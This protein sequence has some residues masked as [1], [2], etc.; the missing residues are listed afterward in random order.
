MV[1]V[2]KR[3]GSTAAPKPIEG[4]TPARLMRNTLDMSKGGV[5]APNPGRLRHGKAFACEV[6]HTIKEQTRPI[7]GEELPEEP[8]V[9]PPVD[10]VIE[11]QE[12]QQH[13][14]LA[15]TADIAIYGGAAGGGKS[16]GI[17]LESLRGV[18]LRGY[19]G[20]VFRRECPHITRPGGLWDTS[21]ELFPAVGGRP[22]ASNLDW[23]FPLGGR[24]QFAHMQLEQD[25]MAWQGSQVPFIGWDELTHFTELQFWYLLSRNR[26]LCGVK[27]YMRA[28]T[29]PEPGSWVHKLIQWWISPRTGLPILERDGVL[30]WFVRDQEGRLQWADS[31]DAFTPEQG[32][33]S[34]TFIRADLKDNKKL[35]QGDPSYR[36]NLMALPL[37][38]RELLL[39]GN[40]NV[41]RS[42]GTRF[43]RAWFKVV[44]EPSAAIA[45]TVRYWDRAGT[46]VNPRNTDPDWTAGVKL[47]K[48]VNGR[49]CLQHVERV[50]TTPGKARA[51]ISNTAS[52]EREAELWL[53]EDPGQAGKSEAETLSIELAE[54]GPR[55]AKPSGSKWVRSGPASSAAERGLI[56]VVE[57]DWNEAF[58]DEAEAFCDPADRQPGEAEGHDDQIDGLSGGFNELASGSTPRARSL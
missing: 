51:I 9:L 19:R 55:F 45:R 29:N 57:G 6:W 12:G 21:C 37:Y 8:R 38:E 3:H 24:V 52:Q 25:R 26:S 54:H 7:P 17:L 39:G 5:N 41:K 30:R 31:P 2:L 50:R 34:I 13:K 16:Y 18:N 33:K 32:A 11:P 46:E 47:S 15:C 53:E 35:T 44:S 42:S 49:Y 58:F 20:V 10:L 56:E 28:T 22:R 4:V 40:W 14:F 48:L 36:A 1:L 43:R 27:P 23:H